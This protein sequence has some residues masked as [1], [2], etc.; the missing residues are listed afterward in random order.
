VRAP[1]K[2]HASQYVE[3]G[4]LSEAAHCVSVESTPTMYRLP[5]QKDRV[6]GFESL[7]D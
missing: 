7:I 4:A 2:E 3:Q 5:A 1:L 6:G